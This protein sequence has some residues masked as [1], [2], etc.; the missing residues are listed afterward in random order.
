MTPSNQV[1]PRQPIRSR[2]ATRIAVPP[3]AAFLLLSSYVVAEAL[4]FRGL[5]RPEAATVSEAAALGHAA[6][7]LE[8]ITAGQNPKALVHVRAGILDS[9]AYDLTALEGAILGR[10]VELVQLL[11]RKGAAGSDTARAIC[12]AR[13]RLP[14]VLP[15]LGVEQA[16]SS[17]SPTDIATA[18][19]ICGKERVK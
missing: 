14:E 18:V 3:V 13:A 9:G 16:P 2:L 1:D 7:A 17:D 15:D 6:R 11:R 19:S 10:H 12:F 5:A 8:L 4:G